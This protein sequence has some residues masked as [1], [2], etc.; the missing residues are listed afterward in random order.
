[1]HTFTGNSFSET[2]DVGKKSLVLIK[3]N[4]SIVN[5]HGVLQNQ[6]NGKKCLI[7]PL[8]ITTLN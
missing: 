2:Q 6:N 1:M 7:L 8:D 3:D 4:I 5:W